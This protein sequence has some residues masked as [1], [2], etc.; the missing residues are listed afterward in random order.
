MYV[1]LTKLS[2]RGGGVGFF[3]DIF[4]PVVLAS[5]PFNP[6][7]SPLHF[8]FFE[9]KLTNLNFHFLWDFSFSIC[10]FCPYH[11]YPRITNH[12]MER[13]INVAAVVNYIRI[14]FSSFFPHQPTHVSN[15]EKLSRTFLCLY[16]DLVKV[17]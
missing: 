17:I 7:L 2:R 15:N 1:G 4:S 16:K 14:D 5:S 13:H 12:K 3:V 9:K 6:N 8:R 11:K 10:F